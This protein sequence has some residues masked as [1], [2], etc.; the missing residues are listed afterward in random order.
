MPTYGFACRPCRIAFDVSRSFAEA[1]APV[2]CPVCGGDTERR[3][4]VPTLEQFAA[5]L[6]PT[7]D[8]GG[9]TPSAG[10]GWYHGHAHRPGTPGHRH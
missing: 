1:D 7:G 9:G 3:W 10:R 8:P 4:T 2:A 6:R 5:T